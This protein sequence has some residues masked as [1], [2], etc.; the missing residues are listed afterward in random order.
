MFCWPCI[1]LQSLWINKL[2]HNSFYYICSIEFPTSFEKPSAHHQESQLNQYE[3]WY[4]S[5]WKFWTIQLFSDWQTPEIVLIQFTLL[6]MSTWLFETCKELEY[7]NIRKTCASGWRFTEN[8]ILC[9]EVVCL[10]IAGEISYSM[11]KYAE[12]L[13]HISPV[14]S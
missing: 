9:D 5:L 12:G 2:R 11:S 4:M 7:T 6:I 3:V 8:E 14:R 13:T 1:L 10:Q